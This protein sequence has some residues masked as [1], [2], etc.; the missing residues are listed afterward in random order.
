MSLGLVRPKCHLQATGW[1]AGGGRYSKQRICFFLNVIILVVKLDWR[2]FAWLFG[3]FFHVLSCSLWKLYYTCFFFTNYGMCR[4]RSQ[5]LIHL[6]KEWLHYYW[7]KPEEII[8]PYFIVQIVLI[9]RGLTFSVITADAEY[10]T[11]LLYSTA[12]YYRQVLHCAD[13]GLNL[14]LA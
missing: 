10:S 4:G 5:L 12:D 2:H 11:K 3:L 9:F 14:W 1:G 6:I 13:R 7:L 8:S